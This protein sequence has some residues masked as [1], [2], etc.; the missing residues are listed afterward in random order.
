MLKKRKFSDEFINIL[1]DNFI[2]FAGVEI[3]GNEFNQIMF[4]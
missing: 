1:G 3:I 2:L 4:N